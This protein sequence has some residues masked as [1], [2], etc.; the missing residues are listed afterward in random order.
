MNNRGNMWVAHRM[1]L[2][3]RRKPDLF[4]MGSPRI[5]SMDCNH[6]QTSTSTP[7]ANVTLAHSLLK[8]FWSKKTWTLRNLIYIHSDLNYKLTWETLAIFFMWEPSYCSKYGHDIKIG[9]VDLYPPT[10]FGRVLPIETRRH[11]AMSCFRGPLCEP[12]R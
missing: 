10:I 5:E 2:A 11:M 6:V 7:E 9:R 3:E 12:S 8:P 4:S 1:P